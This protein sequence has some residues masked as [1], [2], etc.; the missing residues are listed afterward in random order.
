MELAPKAQAL[1]GKGIF[2]HFEIRVPVMA[3]PGI[4]K[5]FFLIADAMLFCQNTH[6]TGNNAVKMSL[7]FQDITQ[8]ESFTGLNLLEYAFCVI[9]PG[10]QMLYNFIQ[11]CLIIFC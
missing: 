3:S 5:R 6:K 9:T 4:F 8:F 11:W 10:K 7:A 2:G 1:K